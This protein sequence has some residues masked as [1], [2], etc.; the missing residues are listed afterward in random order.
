MMQERIRERIAGVTSVA[1]IAVEERYTFALAD[2]R[3]RAILFGTLALVGLLLAATGLYA[4]AA[5]DARQREHEIGVRLVHGAT[6]GDVGRL[7]ITQ[8][9]PPVVAGLALGLIAAFWATRF[10]QQFLYEV[11]PRDPGIF[12]GVAVIMLLT[13]LLAAWLPAWRASRLDPAVVLRAE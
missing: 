2:P 6:G 10:L 11:E 12:A 4:V 1:M 5:V 13:A 8:G 9:L 3:F 7:V